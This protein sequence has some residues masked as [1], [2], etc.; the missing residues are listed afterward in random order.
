MMVNSTKRRPLSNGLPCLGM[1]SPS[2]HMTYGTPD[3]TSGRTTWPGLDWTSSCR[4]SSCRTT[5]L[6]PQSASESEMS[7]CTSRSAP[8]RLNTACSFC[9]STKTTSPGSALGDSLPMPGKRS[10][11]LCEAPLS[12]FTSRTWRSF[13]IC[14]WYPPVQSGHR[15]CSC[16]TMPGP[17][18]R[19]CTTT[20]VPRHVGHFFGSPFIT[21]RVIASLAVLPLYRSSSDTLSGYTVSSAL[22]LPPRARRRPP[23]KNRSNTSMPPSGMSPP[24]SPS[25]PYLSYFSRFSASLSTSY[26]AWIFLNSSGSPPLSG[27][28]L[29]ASFR[30]AFLMS[31]SVAFLSTPSTL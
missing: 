9:C 2:T 25:S 28:F 31:E 24:S 22:R 21:D 6:K 10:L 3:C 7:F 4:P 15:D 11:V 14:T 23:P 19:I 8:L 18:C 29:S 26:A 16:C 1:P 20:P 27:C 13:F 30:N 17:I 5:N 12:T